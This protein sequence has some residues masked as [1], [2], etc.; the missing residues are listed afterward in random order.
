VTVADVIDRRILGT[1]QLISH[2]LLEQPPPAATA[3][4]AD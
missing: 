1:S 3:S 4:G 2:P